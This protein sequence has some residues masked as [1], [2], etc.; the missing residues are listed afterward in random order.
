[1][2]HASRKINVM[3]INQPLKNSQINSFILILVLVKII[4]LKYFEGVSTLGKVSQKYKVISY[5]NVSVLSW[6]ICALIEQ[7]WLKAFLY[8]IFGNVTKCYPQCFSVT[9]KHIGPVYNYLKNKNHIIKFCIYW[10]NI[11]ILT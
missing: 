3:L 2:L 1:M 9:I 11:C 10:V 5:H 7:N 4:Q 6:R 8:C